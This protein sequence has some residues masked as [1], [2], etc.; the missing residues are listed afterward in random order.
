MDFKHWFYCLFYL[1]A[2]TS[3]S[4]SS[5]HWFCSLLTYSYLNPSDSF[6]LFFWLVKW[7][8]HK[9]ERFKLCCLY[10]WFEVKYWLLKEKLSEGPCPRQINVVSVLWKKNLY[11]V[12]NMSSWNNRRS[13]RSACLQF[14]C[15][16]S[17]YGF[18]HS[19]KF[20]LP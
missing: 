6:H 1:N 14:P 5:F 13:I 12:V 17:V 8:R 3:V 10:W 19:S 20:Q 2:W 15:L 4:P 7:H 18:P 11:D 16:A 9:K